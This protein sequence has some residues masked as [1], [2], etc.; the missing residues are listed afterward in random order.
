MPRIR[1]TTAH[2]LHGTLSAA[3]VAWTADSAANSMFDYAVKHGVF[4]VLAQAKT[5]AAEARML[6][7]H[8]MAA[9]ADAWPT[10]VGPLQA[11]RKV[12][13]ERARVGFAVVAE[14]L[15]APED[16]GDLQGAVGT[17][18]D[19]LKSAGL[20]EAGIPLAEWTLEASERTLGPEHPT[21]LSNVGNLAL[22]YVPQ[23]RYAE[24]EPLYLWTLEASE[25]TL[26][27]EHPTTLTSVNN[28]AGLYS[29]QGRYAEAEPLYL[30]TL[31]A[32][33]RT[34]GPEHPTTLI[35]LN[36][37]AALYVPQGRYA[38][39]EPLY[40][41]TLEASE[42]T[43]GPEHPTTLISV[44]NLAVLH[45]SQG[46]YG[47]AEPLYLRALE[48]R[49]CTLGS[50]HPDTLFSVSNLGLLY[51]F[52]GLYDKAE[53]LYL[54]ALEARERTLGL[55]HPDTLT[56][57]SNLAWF[58]LERTAVS[59]ASDFERLPEHW[60]DPTD[61]KHHWIRLGLALCDAL[62]SSEFSM[63][64]AVLA[65]LTELLGDDHDRVAKGREKIALI[66]QKAQES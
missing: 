10:V 1:P 39:A 11:W 19:F 18:A 30:R 61:W 29:A 2:R 54:R 60:A 34:L 31:E 8:F 59:P 57:V 27:P 50:E 3:T 21:T 23:G 12:G 37:L 14:G 64:E 35:W 5:D 46:R 66:R 53:P 65:D 16:A 17:V 58:R 56:S 4:H 32:S 33:E 13:L 48:A 42:R 51:K 20:Y 26:G 63:A 28:L 43:L 40:L 44:G 9:F 24:A 36:N 15:A 47:E 49:E 52:Q 45:Q 25:R 7:L 62:E 41:R 6:D 55:E 22:L 38:E